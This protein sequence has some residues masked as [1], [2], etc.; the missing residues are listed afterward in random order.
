MEVIKVMDRKRIA[1]AIHGF[2]DAGVALMGREKF[3]Q[4]DHAKIKVLRTM[5]PH[6]AAAVSM[7]QQETAQQRIV[8]V[9]ERMKQLGYEEPKQL[10]V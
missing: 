6:V 2:L 9:I 3:E 7:V 5:S 1:D 10:Q 8:V 4:T